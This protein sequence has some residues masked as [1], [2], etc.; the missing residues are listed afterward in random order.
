MFTLIIKEK[1]LKSTKY[2]IQSTSFQE[3]KDSLPFSDLKLE[4]SLHFVLIAH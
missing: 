2:K 3:L 1:T 4:D